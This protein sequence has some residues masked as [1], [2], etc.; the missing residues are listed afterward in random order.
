MYSTDTPRQDPVTVV[1]EEAVPVRIDWNGSRFYVD[2]PPVPRG[3]LK[4]TP[5]GEEADPRFVTGWSVA[6][7]APGGEHHV[8][9]LTSGDGAR[10][11]LTTLDP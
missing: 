6:A 5:E 3:R 1:L 8:F 2:E 10:W 11:W 4:Y 7:S 9:V